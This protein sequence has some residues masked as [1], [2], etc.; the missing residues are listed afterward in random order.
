[1]YKFGKRSKAMLEQLH[2]RLATLCHDVLELQLFD[3]GISCAHRNM[4]E[5]NLACTEGRSGL[6]WPDSKHNKIPAEAF[7]FVLYVN[8]R[9]DWEDLEAWYMAVGVFRGVAAMGAINIRCGAD[10]D[11]DF[12]KTDQTFND[13]PHIEIIIEES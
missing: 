11:G 7:D 1:M 10:W 5:Q 6:R 2:P 4:Y 3:F 8:G 12:T 13:L 9:V